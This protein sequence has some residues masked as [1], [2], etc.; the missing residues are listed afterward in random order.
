LRSLIGAINEYLLLRQINQKSEFRA[1]CD[2][3][4]EFELEF[5]QR[6][7][8]IAELPI[9]FCVAYAVPVLM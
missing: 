2:I 9:D 6:V 8:P 7:A 3:F 1:I 4:V 5:V